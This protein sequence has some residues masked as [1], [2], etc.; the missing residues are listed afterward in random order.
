VNGE[1]VELKKF[2]DNIFSALVSFTGS[3]RIEINGWTDFD[4]IKL[5]IE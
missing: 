2:T 4:Y 1:I 3:K 5:M